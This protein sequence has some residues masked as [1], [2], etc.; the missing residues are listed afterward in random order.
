MY[1]VLTN[2]AHTLVLHKRVGREGGKMYSVL[3]LQK[4]R[5]SRA[6]PGKRG[7]GPPSLNAPLH[8]VI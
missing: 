1:S 3:T 7:E 6:R 2:T 4:S 5:G 8:I